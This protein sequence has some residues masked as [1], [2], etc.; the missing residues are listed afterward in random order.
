MGN[1]KWV[2]MMFVVG[3]L[4]GCYVTVQMTEWIWGF[5][6][7]PKTVHVNLI[8]VGT[9]VIATLLIWRNK[10]TFTKATEI[11]NELVKVTWP[12]RPETSAATIRVIIT[13]VIFSAFLGLFDLIWSWASNA[14]YS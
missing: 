2:H 4:L 12:T 11:V 1:V 6:A 9:A 7:K 14:I 3:G 10:N 13:T 5:F 8:G